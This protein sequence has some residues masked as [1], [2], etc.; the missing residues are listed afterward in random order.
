MLCCV[1]DA[2]ESGMVLGGTFGVAVPT[3]D[4]LLMELFRGRDGESAL[5]GGAGT[6]GLRWR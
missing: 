1:E 4:G 2:W 3:E 6:F 5:T